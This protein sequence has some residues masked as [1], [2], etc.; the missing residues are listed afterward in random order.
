MK[1][2]LLCLALALFAIAAHAEKIA[3][4]NGTVIDPA[5]AKV[6][7]NTT[8]LIDG[9]RIAQIGGTVS[10]DGAR[11]VDCWGTA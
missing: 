3:L 1:K 6:L 2:I 4:V 9:N 7:P 10:V 5:G 11:A 8:V